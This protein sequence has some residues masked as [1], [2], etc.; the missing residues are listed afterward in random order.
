MNLPRVCDK[1]KGYPAS[2]LSRDAGAGPSGRLPSCFPMSA[3]DKMLLLLVLRK[4]ISIV[5]LGVA[6]A[7]FS[8]C[9]EN[10]PQESAGEYVD[11]AVITT[12]VKASILDRP[13]LKILEIKVDTF[14]GVVT[15]SGFVASQAV[16]DEAGQ[17]ARGVSGVRSVRNDLRLR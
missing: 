15:L 10:L 13:T 17:I 6:L 5:F 11:D 4:S 14:Q 16:M 8:G 7:A 2:G 1:A 12:K 3:R 9:A